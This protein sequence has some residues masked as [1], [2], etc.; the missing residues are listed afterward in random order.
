[1][2]RLEIVE[3]LPHILHDV[4][5]LHQ[6]VFH[7]LQAGGLQQH[8]QAA[9][10]KSCACSFDRTSY[11]ENEIRI[12]SVHLYTSTSNSDSSAEHQH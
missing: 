8:T 2:V 12:T 5:C 6:L 9:T 7:V 10:A 3:G 4:R 1:M 11:F